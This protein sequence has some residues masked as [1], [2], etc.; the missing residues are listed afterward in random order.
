[1]TQD[2]GTLRADGTQESDL[3][4]SRT[5]GAQP[6]GVLLLLIGG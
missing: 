4:N 2:P 1:M 3:P 6:C 5:G